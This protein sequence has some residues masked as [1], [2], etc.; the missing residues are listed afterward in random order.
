M[1]IRRVNIE[2]M[3]SSIITLYKKN[4]KVNKFNLEGH[5]LAGGNLV[6]LCQVSVFPNFIF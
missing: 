2:T 6:L 5:Y 4:I 1:I 3:V